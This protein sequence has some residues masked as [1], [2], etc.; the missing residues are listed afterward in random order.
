MAFDLVGKYISLVP[1]AFEI[2]GHFI[3]GHLHSAGVGIK[4]RG[5]DNQYSV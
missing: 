2:A 3:S 4:C 5:K 1:L